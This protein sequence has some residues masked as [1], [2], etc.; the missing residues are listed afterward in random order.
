MRLT[1]EALVQ[2]MIPHRIH[3]SLRQRTARAVLSLLLLR[4]AT[5]LARLEVHGFA[6]LLLAALLIGMHG[7]CF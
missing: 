5:A 3:P 2:A 4:Q 1:V 6:E 7:H